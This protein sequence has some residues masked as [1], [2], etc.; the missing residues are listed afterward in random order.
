[1]R[2]TLLLCYVLIL[3]LSSVTVRAARPDIEKPNIVL[4]FTDDK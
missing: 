2:R 3:S 1:M 4:V